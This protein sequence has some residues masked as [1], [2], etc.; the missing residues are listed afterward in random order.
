MLHG[1]VAVV[2]A[3]LVEGVF[4]YNLGDTEI[5]TMFLV[6]I[7]SAYVA[8]EPAEASSDEPR[9]DLTIP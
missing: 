9:A 4:E 8:L 7:A 2:L 5:L 3:I 1:T 6:V